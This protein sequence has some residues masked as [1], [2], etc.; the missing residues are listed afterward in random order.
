MLV[1]NELNKLNPKPHKIRPVKPPKRHPKSP[2]KHKNPSKKPD[3]EMTFKD[4]FDQAQ[5]NSAEEL[6]LY[7]NRQLKNKN[8]RL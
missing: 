6:L 7:R 2:T 3:R 4:K 8:K 5:I 1:G